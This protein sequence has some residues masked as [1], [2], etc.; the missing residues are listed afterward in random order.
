MEPAAALSALWPIPKR[1]P[2][3]GDPGYETRQRHI[4]VVALLTSGNW[5]AERLAKLEGVNRD[6]IFRWR[7][8]VLHQYDD[9]EAVALRRRLGVAEPDT[10]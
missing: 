8:K 4:R 7:L 1:F 2:D 3:E 9:P 6:T 5:T 10:G